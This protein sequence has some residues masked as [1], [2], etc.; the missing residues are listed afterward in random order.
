MGI[1]S[2]Q[3]ETVERFDSGE[4]HIDLTIFKDIVPDIDDRGVQGD[5]LGFVDR[6]GPRQNEGNLFYT[7]ALDVVA[8][9][10]MVVH[11]DAK[12]LSEGDEG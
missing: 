5:S 2:L 10:G 9:P 1:E 3:M 8:H 11:R 7:H 4:G 12:S 6:D